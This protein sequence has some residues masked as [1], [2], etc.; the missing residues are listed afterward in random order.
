MP[1]TSSNF[2]AEA[3]VIKPPRRGALSDDEFYPLDPPLEDVRIPV[4][5]PH[6][7]ATGYS[8]DALMHHFPDAEVGDDQHLLFTEPPDGDYFPAGNEQGK[9]G[10]SRLGPDIF[11]ALNVP[12]SPTRGEYDA[13][14]LGPP[15]F[16]LEVL[17]P[18][19]WRHD[20][21]RKLSCYQQIGVREC[22]LFDVTGED[23]TG[24]GKELWGFALTPERR[25]PLPE[26]VVPTGERGVRSAVLG[27][28]AYVSE[29]TPSSASGEIWIPTMRWHDPAT[30]EDIPSYDEIVA[31]AEKAK[32]L[33][34]RAKAHADEAK[35]QA[36]EAKA[37]ARA[38]RGKLRTE[39]ARLEAARR[40]RAELEEELRRL[41]GGS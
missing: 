36:H 32:A 17:S 18:S 24:V 34:D 38:E 14:L 25:E 12:R 19:T 5:A 4:S 20:M 21:G 33:A 35:A 30:A 40:R 9:L 3:E 39:L 6:A 10:Q 8:R 7:T 1:D 16:V 41:R 31:R 28:V 22:L 11:V 23:L 29:R 37:R 13:A 26:Y 2:R 15:D 27:L